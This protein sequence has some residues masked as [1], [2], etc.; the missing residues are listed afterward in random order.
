MNTGVTAAGAI[1]E[2]LTALLEE[3]LGLLPEEISPEAKFKEDLG[4]DSL[5]M[6]ELLTIVEAETGAPVEDETA[7]AMTTIGDVI[8]YLSASGTGE[9]A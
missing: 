1:L 9:G 5:D 2:R 6:V 3:K 4:L 8:D 7:L